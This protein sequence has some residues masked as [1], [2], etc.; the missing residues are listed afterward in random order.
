MEKVVTCCCFDQGYVG[1]K[2]FLQTDTFLPGEEA[3]I[4]SEI[5]NT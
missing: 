4:S 1:V 5:D 3:I 2:S